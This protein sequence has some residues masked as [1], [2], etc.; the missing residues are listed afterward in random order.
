MCV[1]V[2]VLFYVHVAVIHAPASVA[3]HLVGNAGISQHVH[4]LSLEVDYLCIFTSSVLLSF[5]QVC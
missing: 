4:E 2:F 3:C 5:T 1:C